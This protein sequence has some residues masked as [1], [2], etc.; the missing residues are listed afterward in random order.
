[1][2]GTTDIAKLRVASWAVL[3]V[4]EVTFEDGVVAACLSDVQYFTRWT[5]LSK[6]LRCAGQ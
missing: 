2:P 5:E 1:M 3:D 6:L 4:G